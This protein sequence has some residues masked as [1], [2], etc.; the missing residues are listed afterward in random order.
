MQLNSP[1]TAAKAVAA[2]E[3][4]RKS[5]RPTDE[6]MILFPFRGRMLRLC[7]AQC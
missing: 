2:K 5:R 6:A 1:A 7:P 3:C 4:L